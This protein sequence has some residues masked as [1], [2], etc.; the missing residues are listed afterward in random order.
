MIRE[1]FSLIIALFTI[2]FT[3]QIFFIVDRTVIV[4]EETLSD[5]YSMILVSQIEIDEVMLKNTIEDVKGIE[6]IDPEKVLQRLQSE[7][8]KTDLGL[9]KK[10]LPR[11]YKVYLS[12]YPT[13]DQLVYLKDRFSKVDGIIKV[14]GFMKSH[15]QIYKLLM[16]FKQISNIFLSAI[17]VVSALL[18]VK[19]MRIWQFEHSERMQIMAL[20]GAPIWMRSAVLFKLAIVDALLST[21]FVVVTFSLLEFNDWLQNLFMMISVDVD[22]FDFFSDSIKLLLISLVMSLSLAT[23]III[24]NRDTKQ[25]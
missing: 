9:V 5:K 18:I 19:E 6:P 23:F 12:Y 10:T 7:L 14:E 8:N 24:R 21:L 2:L 11:F 1:H 20:F 3:L 17:F 15:D 4:Y 25:R 13:P 16:L 22:I